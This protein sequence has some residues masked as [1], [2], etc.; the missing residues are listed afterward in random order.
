VFYEVNFDEETR[1]LLEGQ[2]SGAIAKGGGGNDF[3]TDDALD[4]SIDLIQKI[5][6]RLSTEVMPAIDGQLCAMDVTFSIRADGNGTIMV[7]QTPEVGQFRVTIKRPV[8]KRTTAPAK[9]GG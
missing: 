4:N 5:V 6:A 9:V 3:I 1:I 2:A 7:A 8:I